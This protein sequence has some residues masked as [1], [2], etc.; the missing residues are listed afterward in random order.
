MKINVE[1][2]IYMYI[3]GAF[4]CNIPVNFTGKVVSGVNLLFLGSFHIIYDGICIDMM[5]TLRENTKSMIF[6]ELFHTL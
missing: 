3:N 2:R 6:I 4:Q 5:N 1:L